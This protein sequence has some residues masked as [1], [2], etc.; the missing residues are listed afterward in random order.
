MKIAG[1]TQLWLHRHSRGG[2]NRTILHGLLGATCIRVLALIKLQ[3]LRAVRKLCACVGSELVLL[4][5]LVLAGHFVCVPKVQWS[6]RERVTRSSFTACPATLRT[7]VGPRA[8]KIIAATTLNDDGGASRHDTCS[9]CTGRHL[10]HRRSDSDFADRGSNAWALTLFVLLEH[11]VA[12]AVTSVLGGL[13]LWVFRGYDGW[14]LVGGVDRII[15][16]LGLELTPGLCHFHK[17][18]GLFRFAVPV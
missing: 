3:R 7:P 2:T 12:L 9:L 5:E 11:A 1:V 14:G 8:C 10:A 13:S 18:P 17:V 16:L 15:A 4:S 6:C